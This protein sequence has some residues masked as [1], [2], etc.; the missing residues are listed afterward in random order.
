MGTFANALNSLVRYLNTLP[1]QYCIGPGNQASFDRLN[2]AISAAD[3]HATR[4]IRLFESSV[5]TF[6]GQAI[7]LL[8]V[9]RNESNAI[10][11][12]SRDFR[13]VI[14]AAKRYD[15]YIDSTQRDIWNL[16]AQIESQMNQLE[17]AL[18]TANSALGS[19]VNQIN[20]N[21][22]SEAKKFDDARVQCEGALR[23]WDTDDGK[24]GFTTFSDTRR[25]VQQNLIPQFN[26]FLPNVPAT[27]EIK[28]SVA[29]A[30]SAIDQ[31]DVG[32][33]T[34]PNFKLLPGDSTAFPHLRYG[35]EDRKFSGDAVPPALASIAAAYF[36]RVRRKLYIGDMQY[37]HGGK[38]GIH[39]SHK[40]GIDADVDGTE[41]G[42]YPNNDKPAALALAKDILRAGAALVF[43]ADPAV[44]ADAN[45][46][47]Q[48]NGIGGR[49]QVDAGHDKHFHL[50]MPY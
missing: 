21:V 12:S 20:S 45:T 9:L 13:R 29:A 32:F 33:R 2:N 42:D 31:I 16:S 1:Q 27:P 8:S 23:V 44:V 39:R 46:W 48:A 50:R 34:F 15:S 40:N 36:A 17:F 6:T 25:N 49:L 19:A 24:R 18:N 7:S 37:E 5:N 14:D 47:A 10:T 22:A 43:Y 3:S 30:Q 38:M 41:I 26:A 28:R 11:S 35:N 4:G